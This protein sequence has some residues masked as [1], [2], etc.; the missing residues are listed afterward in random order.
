[1]RNAPRPCE[2][3]GSVDVAAG[4][5]ICAACLVKRETCD[6]CSCR[7]PGCRCVKMSGCAE[8]C[9]CGTD[10]RSQA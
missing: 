5:S 6:E 10:E 1:M 9:G 3:C 7:C 4:D 2:D 8:G